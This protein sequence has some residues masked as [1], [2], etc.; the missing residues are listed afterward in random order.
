MT[1]HFPPCHSEVPAPLSFFTLLRI[2]FSPKLLRA[3][4]S[5]IFLFLYFLV[6]ESTKEL[7]HGVNGG[8]RLR[9]FAERARKTYAVP[10]T[11]SGRSLPRRMKPRHFHECG[12]KIQVPPQKPTVIP[13]TYPSFCGA[14]SPLS[15][16]T[17]PL[18]H[19]EERQCLDEESVS[20]QNRFSLTLNMT[21]DRCLTSLRSLPPPC[22]T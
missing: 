8:I 4:R 11:R 14:L 1:F 5:S 7:L 16:C 3:T 10:N 6:Q 17:H 13:T 2:C 22:M 20:P 12:T 18:C 15:F 9:S 19:S 21:N